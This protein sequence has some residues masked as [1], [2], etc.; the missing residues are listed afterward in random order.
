MPP[1]LTLFCPAKINLFLEV[2]NRRPDG[3]HDILTIMAP[4]DFG[5][6]L[7]LTRARETRLAIHPVD[8][9]PARKNTVLLALA[10]LRRRARF[11][12]H[13]HL[14]LEKRVPMGSGLGGGSSDAA[15]TLL[16]LNKLLDLRLPM[17]VLAEAA[18]E[19]G[20]D[21]P[22]FLNKG[23]AL[24]AGRGELVVP[25]PPRPP[26]HFVLLTPDLPISTP[27]AYEQI[28]RL[29]RRALESPVSLLQQWQSRTAPGLEPSFHNTFWNVAVKLQPTLRGIAEA[30]KNLR[31]RPH[32]SGSGSA[33]FGLCRTRSEAARCADQLTRSTS[34]MARPV[35]TL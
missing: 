4:I 29:K 1:R 34:A 27:A 7:R 31:I 25:L 23:S 16:G 3:Y 6:T 24:C 2:L 13:V 30:M 21:V 8:A 15:A 11:R 17:N 28:D 32:L 10:A 33:L 26:M 9:A 19:V 12:A 35:S 18:A 5:D 14:T 22:F 20:S